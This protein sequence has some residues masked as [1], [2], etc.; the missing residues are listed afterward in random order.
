MVGP[1]RLFAWRLLRIPPSPL[2]P[3]WGTW[4]L[5]PQSEYARTAQVGTMRA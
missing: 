1:Q 5:L 2:V 4:G 3:L